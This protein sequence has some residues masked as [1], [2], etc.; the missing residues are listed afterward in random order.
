VAHR[1]RWRQ[2]ARV[3]A[4]STRPAA[5]RKCATCSTT[6]RRGASSCARNAPNSAMSRIGSSRWRW[7]A[8]TSNSASATTAKPC[9]GSSRRATASNSTAVCPTCSAKNSSPAACGSIIPQ[10]VCACTAG[11]VCRPP[12]AQAD[13]QY[14]HVNG[15]LVRDRLVAHAVRQAYADVCSTGVT[16]RSC[17]FSNSIQRWST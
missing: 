11:S 10:Q 7:R 1:D 13:Q 9:A 4:R 5:P 16:R 15:R 12:R 14:F 17:C 3:G 8:P 2:G 6:C